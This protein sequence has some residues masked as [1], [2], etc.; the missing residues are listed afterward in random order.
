M[1]GPEKEEKVISLLAKYL[2]T[3]GV[4]ADIEVL[5][6]RLG[7]VD[8]AGGDQAGIIKAISNYLKDDTLASE[9]QWSEII[10]YGQQLLAT[11]LP[12]LGIEI[13]QVGNGADESSE[14][15]KAPSMK[16]TTFIENVHD[17]KAALAAS[18]GPRPVV[19][20]SEFEDSEPKL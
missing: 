3:T 13:P 10:E 8:I 19:H 6:Q 7:H 4:N 11:A 16:A 14:L 20:L 5:S 18:A 2:N 15:P 9:D 17:F 1:T 12:S